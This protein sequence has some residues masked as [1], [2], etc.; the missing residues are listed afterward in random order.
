[1]HAFLLEAEGMEDLIA[2]LNDS[3][4]IFDDAA[5]PAKK[6]KKAK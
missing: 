2:H 5:L 3:L 6:A 1:M 4:K